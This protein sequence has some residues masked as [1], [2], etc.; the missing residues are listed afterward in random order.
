[1]KM[2][3]TEVETRAMG[4]ELSSGYSA[5][6]VQQGLQARAYI[7]VYKIAVQAKRLRIRTYCHCTRGDDAMLSW[8]PVLLQTPF[9]TQT[10]ENLPPASSSRSKKKRRK[11]KDV[12]AGAT[13]TATAGARWEEERPPRYGFRSFWSKTDPARRQALVTV[14]SVHTCCLIVGAASPLT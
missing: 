10:I 7:A 5:G 8:G 3:M 13:G 6:L 11:R 4:R 12:A 14:P 9:H 1:M 2:E